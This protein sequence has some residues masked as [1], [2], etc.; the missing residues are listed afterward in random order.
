[1]NKK[2]TVQERDFLPG[3]R[4]KLR[5]SQLNQEKAALWRFCLFRVIVMKSKQHVLIADLN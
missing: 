2:E 3:G 5:K 1:M 4:K